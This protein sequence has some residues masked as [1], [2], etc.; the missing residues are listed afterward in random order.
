MPYLR[1]V[2]C[3]IEGFN[4]KAKPE[5]QISGSFWKNFKI[6]K[7][8]NG[9][10]CYVCDKVHSKGTRYIGDNHYKVCHNNFK[11]YLEKNEEIIK[12]ILEMNSI[13]KQEAEIN[14][15]KYKSEEMLGSL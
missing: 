12:K 7:S 1:F 9:F 13:L 14:K 4:F 10:H 6:K 8:R 3:Y 5:F 15:D 11:E 2:N